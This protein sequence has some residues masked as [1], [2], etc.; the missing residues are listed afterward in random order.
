MTS[1]MKRNKDFEDIEQLKEVYLQKIGDQELEV[2][3]TLT[4]MRDNIT[5]VTL[6]N[7]VKENLLNKPG[8]SFRL[9]FMLV[10]LLLERKKKRSRR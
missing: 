10:T 6:L 7:Q 2:R 9:G 5:G 3:S 4:Q 8:L 1:K